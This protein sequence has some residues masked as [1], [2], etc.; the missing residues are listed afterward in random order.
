M[1]IKTNLFIFEMTQKNR[2]QNTNRKTKKQKNDV[3]TSIR[4][5]ISKIKKILFLYFIIKLFER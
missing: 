2:H 1:K 4:T 5:T 3:Q